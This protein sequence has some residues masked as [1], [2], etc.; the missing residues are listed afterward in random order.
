MKSLHARSLFAHARIVMTQKRNCW[1]KFQAASK[2]SFRRANYACRVK[3]ASSNHGWL[4]ITVAE[5]AGHCKLPPA[6]HVKVLR[7]LLPTSGQPGVPASSRTIVATHR[8][9]TKPFLARAVYL[10]PQR[11]RKWRVLTDFATMK[12]ILSF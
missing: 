1:T 7:K 9:E 6:T 12:V 8:R 11:A 3:K 2:K 10:A 4:C 5:E